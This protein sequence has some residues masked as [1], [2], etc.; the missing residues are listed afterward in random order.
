MP[1]GMGHLLSSSPLT[2]GILYQ[3]LSLTK[4]AI[5]FVRSLLSPLDDALL[6]SNPSNTWR[7]STG[8][9]LPEPT[10]HLR[11]DPPAIDVAP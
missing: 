8:R 10:D 11:A 3:S 1:R 4:H 6:G 2:A 7:A 5:S 9:L